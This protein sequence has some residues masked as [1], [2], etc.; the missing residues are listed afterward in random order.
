MPPKI[1]LKN[2]KKTIDKRNFYG[3]IISRIN[4]NKDGIPK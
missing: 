4:P 1:F 2:F 3:I